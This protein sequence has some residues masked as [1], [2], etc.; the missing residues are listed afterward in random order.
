MEF[1]VQSP[2]EAALLLNAVYAYVAKLH[3]EN[4]HLR[5]QLA[6][7]QNGVEQKETTEEES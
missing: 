4:N 5:E 6:T 7:S 1:N 3:E 2:Q